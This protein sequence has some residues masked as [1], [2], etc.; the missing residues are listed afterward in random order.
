MS[1]VDKLKVSLILMMLAL[2]SAMDAEE[3]QTYGTDH[4]PYW[5]IKWDAS[6]RLAGSTG[7]YM[8]FWSRTGQDGILPV[9]SSGLLTAGTDIFYKNPN[10]LFFEAGTNLVG[11]L[12]LKSPLNNDPVYGFV[13]RLYVSGG[14]KMLHMDVGMKPRQRELSDLSISGGNIIYSRN[15][16][17]IPGINAWSD[18]IYFEKGHWFGVKGN[19]AH[20]Q[21]IDNRF[22]KS[23]Y[24][25]NK[26]LS[27]KIALG[28]KVDL[29]GS[30]EHWAQWGGNSPLYGQQPITFKDFMRVFMAKHGG[31][32][33]SESDRINV[34]GNHLG[35]EMVRLDWKHH[36][37]TLS[38]Q[39]DKPF[40]DGSGVRFQNAPD[41]IWSV[42]CSLKDKTA[43][44]TEV[45][46][47][48]INTTWQS[49]PAHDRPATK[50]EM[51][52][53]DPADPHYGKIILRGCD[54]YFSNSEYMSG[55]TNHGRVFGL[56]LILPAAP[57]EDDGVVAAF[58]STRVRAVHAGL[59]GNIVQGL[60]YAFKGT[61]SLNYG[62]YNDQASQ[63]F[64]TRPW[65]LSLAFNLGLKRLMNQL[66]I[67]LGV[68]LYAD[69]GQLYQNSAGLTLTLSYS[70]FHRF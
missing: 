59:K 17:N 25:H 65:Q 10:G 1:I 33:A 56:P 70:D 9:R 20:Y 57:R 69:I 40:E 43:F 64:D 6:S 8:P 35:R 11:A 28:K 31:E 63:F 29:I 68:G 30:L 36:L 7:E 38:F 51:E 41:G 24:L 60:P 47:E 39:Y 16:R 67:D 48:Y 13:D 26:S 42:Q 27:A 2:P 44:V 32:G 18:W 14:W 49:G 54:S 22:V 34:L 46:L 58:V 62:N 21:Y 15:A 52:K 23:A 12:S 61:F 4:G 66:P 37:F 45:I 3:A 50:E 53:Q 55:W 19:I 5:E